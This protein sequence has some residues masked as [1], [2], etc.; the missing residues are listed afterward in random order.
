MLP[1][2]MPPCGRLVTRPTSFAGG[3]SSLRSGGQAGHC[4]PVSKNELTTHSHR[5][6]GGGEPHEACL[7]GFPSLGSARPLRPTNR[8]LE[9][10]PRGIHVPV[11]HQA[12]SLSLED[13]LGPGLL[14]V[15]CTPS[16]TSLRRVGR[17]FPIL[18]GRPGCQFLEISYAG[19]QPVI[20]GRCRGPQHPPSNR[21]RVGLDR[22][23]GGRA[24][25]GHWR[26]CKTAPGPAWCPMSMGT[27][28]SRPAPGGFGRSTWVRWSASRPSAAP[29]WER[30][31]SPSRRRAITKSGWG[32]RSPSGAGGSE[33]RVARR[34]TG[35]CARGICAHRHV[36]PARTVS[37]KASGRNRR[38]RK[39]VGERR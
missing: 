23:E 29:A 5:L 10:V 13:A 17:W 22:A 39:E 4:G 6:P 24:G 8:E 14:G 15:H 37:G 31:A 18:A 3:I 38:G 33:E 11:D 16:R 36:V 19:T 35:R 7:V 26:G 2:G 21:P 25:S 1:L 30:T 27:C 20:M 9:Q 28:S 12:A 34:L 32:S